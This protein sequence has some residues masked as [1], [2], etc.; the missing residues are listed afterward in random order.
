MSSHLSEK[1]VK[2]KMIDAY[3]RKKKTQQ[4]EENS[5]TAAL[6]VQEKGKPKEDFNGKQQRTIEPGVCFVCKKERSL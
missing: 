3:V 4:D 5:T 2:N 6:T 1:Y